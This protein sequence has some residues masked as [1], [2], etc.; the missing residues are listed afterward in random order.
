MLSTDISGGLRQWRR[1][2]T[3]S[4][5][6]DNFQSASPCIVL[7]WSHSASKKIMP[8][9]NNWPAYFRFNIALSKILCFSVGIFPE[10]NAKFY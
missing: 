2:L 8:L 1:A 7:D 4:E 5:D 9:K 3:Q 6:A 10:I